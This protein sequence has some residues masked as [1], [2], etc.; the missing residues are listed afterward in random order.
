MQTHSA[1]RCAIRSALTIG[2]IFLVTQLPAL[3]AI[4][5][6]FP[7]PSL[8]G[9]LFLLLALLGIALVLNPPQALFGV[10]K[11]SWPTRVVAAALT[12]TAVAIYPYAD[13]LK[14]QGRGSDA[15]DA[16]IIAGQALW[17]FQNPYIQETY[18]GNPIAPGPGWAVLAS[19]FS[20][21]G[22]Y[23]AF[24]PATLAVAIWCLRASRY[25][26]LDINRFMLLLASSLCVWELTAVGNDYLPFALLTLCVLL[27]L[28]LES[29]SC[30]YLMLLTTLVGALAT[31]RLPF[32]L[33]PPL[34]AFSL[35]SSFPRR[36]MIVACWA[37]AVSLLLHAAFLTINATDYPPLELLRAKTAYTFSPAGLALAAAVCTVTALIM[38]F[39]WRSWHPLTHVAVGLGVPWTIVAVADLV[40]VSG[41]VAD[42]GGASFAAMWMPFLIL[43]AVEPRT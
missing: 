5:K 27:G 6:F 18:L 14:L 42:W 17:R 19:P 8:T 26:W 38:I 12:V 29:I 34:I 28:Q 22:L 2:L 7:I 35:V 9:P 24:F 25:A 11:G 37:T 36:A 23:V 30:L 33:L 41:S 39:N 15:D 3:R 31:F 32:L 1:D 21:T 40:W 16:L 43:A 13:A 4:A 20:V 10:M